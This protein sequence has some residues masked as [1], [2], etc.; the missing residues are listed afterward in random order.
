MMSYSNATYN[1]VSQSFIDMSD[2]D[3]VMLA[4]NGDN[5]AWEF[6]ICKYKNFVRA[7]VRSYFLIGADKEDIL[8][9]GMLGLYKAIRD[10]R[11]DRLSSFRAFAELC[12]RR[13]I[14]TAIKTATRQKH[15][16]LNSSISL[17]RTICETDRTLMDTIE[18]DNSNDPEE[19]MLVR[20]EYDNI[21]SRMQEVLSNFEWK[22]LS[23]YME[24]VPYQA[25]SRR[26]KCSIKSIDNAI[27]RSKRK[28]S[29]CSEEDDE[30]ENIG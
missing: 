28:L 15:F 22:V 18:E 2:E 10:F 29:W 3:I 26:L 13:Q 7:K 27:Q 30:K 5:N 16:A 14:I 9:E 24:G 12:I 20:E 17:N 1:D 11:H 25:I 23:L 19:L 8:Q 6:L 21:K 4:T